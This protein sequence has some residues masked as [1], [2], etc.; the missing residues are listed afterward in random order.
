MPLFMLSGCSWFGLNDDETNVIELANNMLKEQQNEHGEQ[1]RVDMP[2]RINY[3]ITRKAQIDKRMQIEFEIITE[4]ALPIL[5]FALKTTEGLELDGHNISPLYESLT[6]RQVIKT[7]ASVIPLVEDK[8]Y[9]EL[10]VI[11]EIGEEKLAQLI[12]VPVAVGD[13]SLN[14]DPPARE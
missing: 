7:E 10:Y 5:R 6:A 2:V 8:F 1:I 4:K 13:Y 9:L 11:S 3:S 14:N 12:R